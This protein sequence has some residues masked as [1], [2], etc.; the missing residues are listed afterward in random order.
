M[1]S[2]QRSSLTKKLKLLEEGI[3]GAS[4]TDIS[5][6]YS[7]SATQVWDAWQWVHNGKAA[8]YGNGVSGSSTDRMASVRVDQAPGTEEDAW[9]C[10]VNLLDSC[11]PNVFRLRNADSA[12][13]ARTA[14]SDVVRDFLENMGIRPSSRPSTSADLQGPNQVSHS[15]S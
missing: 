12:A 2:A 7:L 10:G 6:V 8:I 15:R 4:L 9:A 11:P 3:E 1:K 14:G 5:R 13:G